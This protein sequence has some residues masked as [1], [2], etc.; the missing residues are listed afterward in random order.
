MT[1]NH[2]IKILHDQG[3]EASPR[4]PQRRDGVKDE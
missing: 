4:P 1:I 3:R 2:F